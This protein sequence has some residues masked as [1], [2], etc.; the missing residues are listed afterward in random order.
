MNM[1]HLKIQS[2][3]FYNEDNMF[4]LI[5]NE[6]SMEMTRKLKKIFLSKNI[7]FQN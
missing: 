5:K 3:S 7:S 2:F 1:Q 6:T 4:F